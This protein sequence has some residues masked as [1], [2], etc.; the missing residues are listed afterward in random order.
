MA[1]KF[2]ASYEIKIGESEY[3]LRPTFEAVMEFQ[4]KAKVGV[5]E[6]IKCLE[7]KPDI[8]VVVAAIWAGIKG[9]CIFQGETAKCPSF[10]Q[11]G[12]E[13]MNY[14]VS[15]VVFDAFA[16]LQRASAPDEQKKSIEEYLEKVKELAQKM[17]MKEPTGGD[18]QAS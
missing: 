8:K 4:D 6:G 14:G 15:K 5:F 2:R 12:S 11:L 13:I 18:T 1:N 9:E 10:N 7:G 17:Q 3:T 16:F